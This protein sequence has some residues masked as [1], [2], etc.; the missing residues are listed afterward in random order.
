MDSIPDA[1]EKAGPNRVNSSILIKVNKQ[2]L[3][4]ALDRLK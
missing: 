1:T 2:D 3:K 4:R